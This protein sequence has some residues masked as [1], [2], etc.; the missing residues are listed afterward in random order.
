MSVL[1]KYNKKY[2]LRQDS[3]SNRSESKLAEVLNDD[4]IQK[5]IKAKA[6]NSQLIWFFHTIIRFPH[7]I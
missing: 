7:I 6:Y 2:C 4:L 5:L 3:A 1:K